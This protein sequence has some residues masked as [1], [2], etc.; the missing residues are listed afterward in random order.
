MSVIPESKFKDM[1]LVIER[2]RIE[3]DS[4]T[5]FCD[6]RVDV[7]DY[8]PDKRG[9]LARLFDMAA[10]QKESK[11]HSAWHVPAGPT[12]QAKDAGIDGVKRERLSE[13]LVARQ[14]ND[15]T[16][17]LF[18]RTE[19]TA[20]ANLDDREKKIFYLDLAAMNLSAAQVQGKIKDFNAKGD[21]AAE[22]P[23]PEK[24]NLGYNVQPRMI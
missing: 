18:V 21:A 12:W 19:V 24:Q 16:W 6:K 8:A 10:V 2:E 7:A 1:S 23:R 22:L 20:F 13:Q 11:V 5:V 4:E 15:S 3:N 17:D 9:V 14:R